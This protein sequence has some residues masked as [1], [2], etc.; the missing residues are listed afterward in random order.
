MR[1]VIVVVFG[2]EPCPSCVEV[3]FVGEMSCVLLSCITQILSGG[4]LCE[5]SCVYNIVK[6]PSV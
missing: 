2:F 1:E 4:S 6:N 3:V 5:K